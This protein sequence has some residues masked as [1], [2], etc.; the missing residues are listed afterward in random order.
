MR[1]RTRFSEEAIFWG[2]ES[3]RRSCGAPLRS[4]RSIR[5]RRHKLG[6][7]AML[8]NQS[9]FGSLQLRLP[10]CLMCLRSVSRIV[11]SA[12]LRQGL[13]KHYGTTV[14]LVLSTNT[15]PLAGTF[16]K[17]GTLP[18]QPQTTFDRPAGGGD[19]E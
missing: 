13:Q 1:A 2:H 11:A 5:E 6:S 16:A 19:S 14:G 4:V 10:R 12:M 17:R 3:W 7:H 8:Q 9:M 18:P 15:S